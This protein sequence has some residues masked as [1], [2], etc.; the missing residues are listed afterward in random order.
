[1][2]ERFTTQATWGSKSSLSTNHHFTILILNVLQVLIATAK[3][4]DV[5]RARARDAAD[6][7]LRI[8]EQRQFILPT[9]REQH[10][11]R[12]HTSTVD[13]NAIIVSSIR[14]ESESDDDD[15]DGPT[16]AVAQSTPPK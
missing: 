2:I 16:P 14:E 11:R 15:D 9:A 6:R 8:A 10:E 13:P 4:Q 7:C 1:M 3:L 5:K 12:T